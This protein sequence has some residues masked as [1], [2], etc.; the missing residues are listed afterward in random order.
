MRKQL[1][2]VRMSCISYDR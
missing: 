1:H 2:I